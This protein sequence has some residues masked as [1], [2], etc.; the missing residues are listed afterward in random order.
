MIRREFIT[1]L[2]GKTPIPA[3]LASDR[4]LQR[5]GKKSSCS[6][7]TSEALGQ[8]TATSEVLRAVPVLTNTNPGRQVRPT[9]A[10]KQAGSSRTLG[11][12]G[13]RPQCPFHQSLLRLFT[14]IE[15]VSA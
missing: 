15:T 6:P 5:A 14:R 9:S 2:G 10:A 4:H 1:L 13:R 11:Y 12:R 3:M 8:Q 7:A